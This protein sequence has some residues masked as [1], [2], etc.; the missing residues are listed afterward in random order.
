[1]TISVLLVDD[2][3]VVREGLRRVLSLGT[4]FDVVGECDDADSAVVTAIATQPDVVLM[5]LRMPGRDGIAATRE[6]LAA[7]ATNVVVLTT[8]E[9]DGDVVSAMAAGASGYLLKDAPT[10]EL[11]AAV[12]AAARGETV[13]GPAAAA[14]LARAAR[15]PQGPILTPR[16]TDVVRGVAE[17][18]S[19]RDIG[20]RLHIGEATVKSHLL[21]VFEKLGVADRTAAVTAAIARGILPVPRWPQQW[22]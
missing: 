8:F 11:R 12:R 6:V 18:L 3:P 16:E 7:C 20:A 9:A 4:E 19:N 14:A 22:P 13:L 5:D 1:M 2:H 21:R 17:G 10:H 15:R